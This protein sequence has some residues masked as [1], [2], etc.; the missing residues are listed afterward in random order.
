MDAMT[1]PGG[2][3]APIDPRVLRPR[4]RW[5]VV[6][7]ILAFGGLVAFVV[8]FRFGVQ[9]LFPTVAAEFGAGSATK[10][11]LTTDQRW[12][13]Y[14]AIRAHS[15]DHPATDCAARGIDG[16]A[17][18]L[19]ATSYGWGGSG[20]RGAAN[21]GQ[22]WTA[23][24]KLSVSRTGWYELTCQGSDSTAARG[25]YAVGDDPDPFGRTV[26]GTMAVT[27]GLPGLALVGGGGLAIAIARRRGAHR[28]RLQGLPGS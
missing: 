10:V 13:I 1:G 26:L 6:A 17:I 11:R 20:F 12:A 27:A 14:V 5:Y 16:G 18:E 2:A 9:T 8:L 21:R 24:Y 23:A 3:P 19:R 4:L 22:T 7:Q 15:G 25:H 28:R